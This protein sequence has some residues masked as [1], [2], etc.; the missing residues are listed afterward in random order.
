MR[1]LLL[2]GPRMDNLLLTDQKLH[3]IHLHSDIDRA[4]GKMGKVEAHTLLEIIQVGVPQGKKSNVPLYLLI[5]GLNLKTLY[6]R[7]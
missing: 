6:S 7:L 5:I 4:D 1:K 3:V 2:V